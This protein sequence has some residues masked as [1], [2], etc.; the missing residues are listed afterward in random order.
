MPTPIPRAR[1]AHLAATDHREPGRVIMVDDHPAPL[2]RT[3][4]HT[5]NQ[6]LASGEPL[7]LPIPCPRCGWL[8]DGACRCETPPPSHTT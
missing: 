3:P 7:T 1:L 2:V 4:G 8:P 5:V 6:W